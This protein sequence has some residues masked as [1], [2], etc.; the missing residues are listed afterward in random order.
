MVAL[1]HR[2]RRP[3][4]WESPLSLQMMM[5]RDLEL[6]CWVWRWRRRKL[7]MWSVRHSGVECWKMLARVGSGKS[8]FLCLGLAGLRL[9]STHAVTNA[10]TNL[11]TP[12]NWVLRDRT[13]YLPIGHMSTSSTLSLEREED[14]SSNTEAAFITPLSYCYSAALESSWHVICE[15]KCGAQARLH[16]VRA[17]KEEA[18][19]AAHAHHSNNK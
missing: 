16:Y 18:Y 7:G 2:T 14:S 13:S 6:E 19:H 5:M 1:L 15:R 17:R 12:S 10:V 8:V 9:F 3:V 11:R 4:D